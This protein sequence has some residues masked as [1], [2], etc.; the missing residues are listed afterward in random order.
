MASSTSHAELI[1]AKPLA[2]ITSRRVE[3]VVT[4]IQSRWF[5]WPSLTNSP[6]SLLMLL[7]EVAE[8][9]GLQA[10]SFLPEPSLPTQVETLS[11]ESI[12]KL[13]GSP[14]RIVTIGYGNALRGDDAIGI[15]IAA[16]V[17]EWHLP[18]VRSLAVPQLTPEI[19]DELHRADLAVFIDACIDRE[20][21]PRGVQLTTL[22]PSASS[23][24]GEHAS[25]PRSLLAL[26]RAL[27]GRAPQAWWITV[28]GA[29]FEV[30]DRLS[31]LAERG[32]ARALSCL[33]VLLGVS[34]LSPKK[35]YARAIARA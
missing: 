18:Q 2:L 23:R 12:A 31:L 20:V 30:S 5:A 15:R 11:M 28:P 8:K 35:G 32:M 10:A 29:N 24:L 9:V 14:R 26:T 19:V 17:A 4:A 22:Y 34:S 6:N 16:T 3:D 27:Y 33:E 21:C 1:W 25:D 7:G 13:P